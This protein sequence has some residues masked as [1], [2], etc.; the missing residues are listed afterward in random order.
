M[1]QEIFKGHHFSIAASVIAAVAVAMFFF[2]AP[3]WAPTE[4]SQLSSSFALMYALLTY[5]FLQMVA[6]VFYRPPTR[7]QMLIDMLSSLLP[8]VILLPSGREGFGHL[9]RRFNPHAVSLRVNHLCHE[10]RGNAIW[11]GPLLDAVLRRPRCFGKGA[12]C[13]PSLDRAGRGGGPN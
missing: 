8:M 13:P 4:A 12:S 11:Q 3:G 7:R 5:L 9:V 1:I 10:R 6:H 2:G